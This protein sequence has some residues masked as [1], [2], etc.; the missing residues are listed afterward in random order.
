MVFFGLCNSPFRA[1]KNDQW[2][3]F[4]G[5]VFSMNYFNKVCQ[6]VITF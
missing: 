2:F 4:N 6:T 5:I 1:L 3:V